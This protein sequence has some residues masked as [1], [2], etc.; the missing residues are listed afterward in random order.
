MGV[1][2]IV[3]ARKSAVL[4][5]VGEGD[6]VIAADAG[7][8]N[9][10]GLKPDL[11]VGDF[12]SLG[13]MPAGENVVLH[14]KRKDDTDTMLAVK[15]GLE[16]G[17]DRFVIIGGLGGRLDHTLANIHALAFLVRHGARGCLIG[18]DESVLMLKNGS[19]NF[20]PK[21]KGAISVFAYGGEA[22][23]VTLSGLDYPLTDATL[24]CDFPL[25]VSNR[26]TG[27]ETCVSV[28]DG[29][30]LVIW[31]GGLEDTDFLRE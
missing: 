16:K 27:V 15:L 1:C 13:Y 25:G 23:G 19:V 29:C 8:E 21:T 9:L 3:G 14:P 11:V 6:F 7:Y 17:F 26:F 4:P 10:G 18:E 31:Q 5:K 30:L 2:Y 12:D 28:A 20:S 24:D 22:R